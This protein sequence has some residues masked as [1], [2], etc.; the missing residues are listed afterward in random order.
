MKMKK[1]LRMI[2]FLAL[3]GLLGVMGGCGIPDDCDTEDPE[4]LN[5]PYPIVNV[6]GAILPIPKISTPPTLL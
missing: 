3:I 4:N 1:L 6:P 2:A 5:T